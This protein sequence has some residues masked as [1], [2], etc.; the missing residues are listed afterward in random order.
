YDRRAY[1]NSIFDQQDIYL[2]NS[3]AF[4]TASDE[5][6]ETRFVYEDRTG[7]FD[8]DETT[9]E[10]QRAVDKDD[11][12]NFNWTTVAG[13]FWGA[14]GEFPFTGEYQERYRLIIT[15]RET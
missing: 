9:L 7:R 3:T 8:Q 1:V 2:L 13:D 4:P 5:A 6:I 10:I 11:D 14:A 15:N 12:G